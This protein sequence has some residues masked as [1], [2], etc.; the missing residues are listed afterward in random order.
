MTRNFCFSPNPTGIVESIGQFSH[1]GRFLPVL[2]RDRLLRVWDLTQDAVILTAPE[3]TWPDGVDFRPDD[4]CV[5]VVAG[6][7]EVSIY[8]LATGTKV[9]S[10]ATPIAA[11]VVRYDPSGQKLA[12]ST[13]G[14]KQL[15]ILD[16]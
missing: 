5:A 7:A 15:A 16:P 10:F 2:C 9:N 4:Q 12:I 3:M 14:D 1:D 6:H 11:T 13:S 8:E